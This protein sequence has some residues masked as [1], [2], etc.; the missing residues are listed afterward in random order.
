MFVQFFTNHTRKT[1]HEVP[2]MPHQIANKL[3]EQGLVPD[4]LIRHGIRNL[5][6]Q[7]L[8]SIESQDVESTSR[9]IRTILRGMHVSPIAEL[10]HKANEQ[11]YE[12]PSRFFRATLGKQMKYSCAYWG[13]GV[14]SLD[15]AEN[16]ALEITCE[17]AQ[18]KDG[19][20]I[21]ELGCGWGSLTLYMA[22]R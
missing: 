2:R 15:E 8:E 4:S 7:R 11:H 12:I 3:S 19:M 21:L 14:E 13:N 18:L 5:L 16:R 9:R 22:R 1:A 6:R 17:R 10:P 20:N